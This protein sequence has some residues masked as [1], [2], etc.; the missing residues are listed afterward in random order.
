MKKFA[1]LLAVFLLFSMNHY[2]QSGWTWMNPLPEGNTLL[3]VSVFGNSYAIAVGYEGLIMR[4]TD[5]GETW[6]KINSG[7]KSILRGVSIHQNGT[8]WIVGS[9]SGSVLKTMDNGL[10]WVNQPTGISKSYYVVETRD[11]VNCIIAGYS[12]TVCIT[13]D[14]G[15]TWTNRPTSSTKSIKA[16]YTDGNGL[17]Y[18]G[19]DGGI[20]QKSTDNGLTWTNQPTPTTSEIADIKFFGNTGIAVSTW[21]KV[22]RTTD[23][24]ATWTMTTFEDTGNLKIISI[25][26][27]NNMLIWGQASKTLVSTNGGASFAMRSNSTDKIGWMNDLF[28][29]PNGYFLGV[30]ERGL[31]FK[32]TNGTDWSIKTNGFIENIQDIWF[33]DNLEGFI[34]GGDG[35]LMKTTDGGVTWVSKNHPMYPPEYTCLF[36]INKTIGFAGANHTLYKTTNSGENWTEVMGMN[37]SLKAPGF[38]KSVFFLDRDNGWTI[39]EEGIVCRTADGGT[40]WQAIQTGSTDILSDIVFT[41]KLHG[42]AAGS[43][44]AFLK[45]IDGG[46]NWN[47]ISNSISEYISTMHAF[48]Q[49][50]IIVACFMGEAHRTYDG[51]LTWNPLVLPRSIS[52]QYFRQ[53]RFLDNKIGW[54]IA[55]PGVILK[56]TDGGDTWSRQGSN[57]GHELNSVY[58]TDENHGWACGWGGTIIKTV[59]GGGISSVETHEISKSG[60]NLV[61]NYPNPFDQNTTLTY[62][63]PIRS[64]V[65]LELYSLTG[66]KLATLLQTEKEA[67]KYQI[68]IDGSK[69]PVGI[70]FCRFTWG[71]PDGRSIRI[72]KN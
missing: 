16:L 30:G 39:A 32:S 44:G 6:A 4:S 33:T 12:G 56:T 65:K 60:F 8:G 46:L 68:T 49:D 22:L 61:Q 7:T 50:S 28:I 37:S 27:A 40:T 48:N 67:G 19:H 36:F 5:N 1:T 17:I 41:D 51:G 71:Q 66:S 53:I 31:L 11:G 26:D 70:Y 64:P 13:S 21:G 72:L 45:T 35:L 2:G 54:M 63:L 55:D 34:A 47:Q 43:G 24:G 52:Y 62:I 58:F 23:A 59:D 18:T 25:L 3:S 20:I 57:V 14:G 15:A 9:S 10:T 38:I 42:F 29:K 69:L